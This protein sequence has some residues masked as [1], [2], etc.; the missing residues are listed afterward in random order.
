MEHDP[1]SNTGPTCPTATTDAGHPLLRIQGELDWDHLSPVTEAIVAAGLHAKGVVRLDLRDVPF[2]SSAGLRA[3]IL[4][5]RTLE[6]L[7][8]EVH[9]VDASA[10]HCSSSPSPTWRPTSTFP[11]TPSRGR[12]RPGSSRRGTDI[13]PAALAW[14]PSANRDARAAE[15]RAR[16]RTSWTICGTLAVVTASRSRELN[17]G[18]P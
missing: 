5:Q 1:T 12:G 16:H 3:L 13:A 10:K 15:L 14:E 2:M 8:K 17:R 4:T 6:P 9:I 18:G 7:G 11:S